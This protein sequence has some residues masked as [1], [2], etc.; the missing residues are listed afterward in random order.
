VKVQL[1]P[2]QLPL[3][4]EFRIS[5]E[6]TTMQET[7]VIGL[8]QDGI[9][10]YGESSTNQYYGYTLESM[11][12][13]AGE[14]QE[15]LAGFDCEFGDPSRLWESLRAR[16]GRDTFT[17]SAIDQAVYDLQG[18]LTGRPTYEALGLEWPEAVPKS[19]YTIGI[20]TVP[21]MLEKLEERPGWSVY[22]I[23]LGT[24]HDVEIVRQLRTATDAVLRVDA[25][26]GWTAEEAIANSHELKAL[27][28]EFIEQPLPVEALDADH[29]RVFRESVLPIV[30]DES[31]QVESDV[32]RFHGRFHG[33]NIKLCKC[34]GL[35]PGARMLRQARELGMKTMVGCMLE[36]SVGISAG[37]QLLPLLDYADLD[38]A[39]LLAKDVATGV[40][41]DKGIIELASAPG[42]AGNGVA[43]L[44]DRDA[45]QISA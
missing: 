2:F 36:S 20:D 32:A 9:T 12:R 31:C 14:C 18:K 39:V 42:N 34:G 17:L 19:S 23:K 25:N 13:A 16:L 26:C 28:V 40:R 33:V 41:V 4:H 15:I 10:G 37:A 27:G 35:T 7:L 6:S 30:A 21:R 8:E 43:L 11:S 44:T 5:R 24:E 1:H 3:E 22:K 38:G 45:K 29:Q